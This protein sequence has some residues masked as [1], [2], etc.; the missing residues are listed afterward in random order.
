MP[1]AADHGSD[2]DVLL[3]RR[4]STLVITINRAS[5]RNAINASVAAGLADALTE[6]DETPTLAAAVIQG[7]G[8]NFSAGLDLKA[9]ARGERASVPGRGFAGIVESPPRKPLI[10]AVEGWA[11]GGGFEI[12]LACDLTVAGES[13]RFGL[14]EVRRGLVARGGGAFRLPRRLPHAV[15][16]E[17]LLTGEPL[18]AARAER[19][20]LINRVVADGHAIDAAID[21]AGLIA[22]NAPLSVAASKRV[23]IESADWPVGT[24]FERQ[25]HHFDPVFA[26]SDAREGAAA[27]RERREPTWTGR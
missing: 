6:L 7:A 13:A 11:L 17:V 22:R 19:F 25:R 15:A 20:G 10:A 9:F 26:S 24:G 5:Q 12:V 16:M 8:G 21:L 3:A 18:S 23:L 4:E 2:Q 14:P 1:I 27:F